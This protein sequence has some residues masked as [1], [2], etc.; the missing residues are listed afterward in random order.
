MK[1]ALAFPKI[2]QSMI[3]TVS[4]YVYVSVKVRERERYTNP[5]LHNNNALVENDNVQRTEFD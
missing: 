3:K 1:T 4:L 5:H 2:A